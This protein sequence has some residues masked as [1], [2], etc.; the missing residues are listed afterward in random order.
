M[1]RQAS[2]AAAFAAAI[3]PM[4]RVL[5]QAYG[6]Y[7]FET[8]GLAAIPA[9]IAPPGIGGRSEHG[10]FLTHEHALDADSVDVPVFAHELAHM[11]WANTV[12]SDPPG[13]DMVDE[14]M[15][16]QGA[17][18]V[19]E[20]RH[21]RAAAHEWM[22]DGS[23]ANSAHTWF[24]LWRIGADEPLMNDFATLPSYGKGAWV[25]EMLRGR[26]GDSAY[27]ATLRTLVRERA[28]V[29]TTL[30][31]LRDAFERAAP[32]PSRPELHRF[33]AEWLDRPG[34]PVLDVSWTPTTL[35]GQ[36]AAR[37]R[38]VQRTAPYHLP[39]VI[40]VAS[41]R[42]PTRHRVS[43][44]DSTQSFVLAARARPTAVRLD[45]EHALIL[46]EPSFGPIPGVTL[47]QSTTADRAWLAG[48]LRWLQKV[49]GVHRLAVG[50][51]RHGGLDWS[52]SVGPEAGWALGAFAPAAHALAPEEIAAT[53]EQADVATFASLLGDL[54]RATSGR[55]SAAARR[56][57]A[58]VVT[59]PGDSVSGDPFGASRMGGLGFRLATKKGAMR[60]SLVDASRGR[61][62]VAF[63]Y[64]SAGAGCVILTD[65]E[66]VGV[67]LATQVAQRLAVLEKWP[68]IPG[69]D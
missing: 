29:S 58:R 48:E 35:R 5:E 10:Y 52:A 3:P 43:L 67:G 65:D 55:D 12:I 34:A 26:L 39:L 23:I 21:G 60:F 64:P 7:P 32:A 31:D 63:G 16:S 1:P 36:A 30:R 69:R 46:W 45:P 54:L 20:A 6:P 66:R 40:E 51:V 22:R 19:V 57:V 2:K 47:P 41:A 11:W 68:E 13:D 24:H 18:L 9:G 8:F 33:L 15:A 28:G 61:T 44:V 25:Y 53:R 37:V 49:Y 50:L 62:L 4:V 17:T 27:F 14:G 38:I 56:A 42:G 59:T